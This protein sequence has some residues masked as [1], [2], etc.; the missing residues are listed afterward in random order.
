MLERYI[1]I[2]RA[3]V[4][5]HSL[6]LVHRVAVFQSSLYSFLRS[7]TWLRR[8]QASHEAGWDVT[9]CTSPPCSQMQNLKK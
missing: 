3:P 4:L 9:K 2:L 7:F 5:L 8:E 1:P 6:R